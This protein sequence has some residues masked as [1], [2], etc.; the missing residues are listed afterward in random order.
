[1]PH[2]EFLIRVATTTRGSLDRRLVRHCV[3]YIFSEAVLYRTVGP[4]REM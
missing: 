1:M 3:W 2:E 4:K